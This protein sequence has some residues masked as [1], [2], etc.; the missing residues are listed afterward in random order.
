LDFIRRARLGGFEI[1]LVPRSR[2]HHFR[3]GG[4]KCSREKQRDRAFRY[5]RGHLIYSLTDPARSLA[6]NVLWH[7]LVFGRAAMAHLRR[8][9]LERLVALCRAEF[10]VCRLLPA[11]IAKWRRDRLHLASLQRSSSAACSVA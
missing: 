4:W 9:Q 8:G 3:G 11:L 6:R 2:C 5:H 10:R 7:V 1:A